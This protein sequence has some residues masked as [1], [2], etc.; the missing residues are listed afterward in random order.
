MRQRSRSE[1]LRFF[2]HLLESEANSLFVRSSLCSE[3]PCCSFPFRCRSRSILR[4]IW[5]SQHLHCSI[6]CVVSVRETGLHHCCLAPDSAA[7]RRCCKYV[8]CLAQPS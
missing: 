2:V 5:K 4:R 7:R 6:N 3:H 8:F 1:H